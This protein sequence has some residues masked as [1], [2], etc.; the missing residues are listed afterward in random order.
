MIRYSQRRRAA[1]RYKGQSHALGR[2]Q[3]HVD[4]HVDQGLQAEYEG[5]AFDRKPRSG[6]RFLASLEQR[7]QNDE[8]EKGG[9]ARQAITPYSSATT[10]KMKSVW[11][12]GNTIL[13]VP[14]PG[15]RPKKPP[16]ENDWTPDRPDCCRR[17]WGQKS[18]HPLVDVGKGPIGRGEPRGANACQGRG[19]NQ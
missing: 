6:V 9:S 3:T 15:P 18:V 2:K 4:T 14:S 17:G 16:S 1:S 7:A 12:S 5:K 11:A 10:A 8:G 19:A 13:M